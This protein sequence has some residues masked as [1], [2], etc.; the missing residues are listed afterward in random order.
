MTMGPF[1]FVNSI[2]SSKKT[3]LMQEDA[4]AEKEYSPFLTNKALSYFLDTLGHANRM[5]MNFH[6]DNKLQYQYLLN[7][8]RPRKRHSK[9]VK[10]LENPDLDIIKEYYGY[11]NQKAE[12][13]LSVLSP[14]QINEIKR[15]LKG[16]S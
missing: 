10:K 2:N 3:N 5:N 4:A 1:D 14:D 6:L 15:R 16:W 9:W 7:I 8:V 11:N 12:E 13:A